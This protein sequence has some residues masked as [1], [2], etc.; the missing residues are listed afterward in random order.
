MGRLTSETNP[1]SGT[2]TYYYDTVPAGCY[3]FGDNQSGNLE[4]KGDANGNLDCFHYD[5][6]HR[7]GSIGTQNNPPNYAYCK[8][9]Q[10][11]AASNGVIGEPSGVTVNNVKG[12]LVEAETDNCGTWPPTPITDEWFSYTPRGEISD[13]WESTPHSGGY[14][15]STAS[16]WANGALN[17]LT[18]PGL[19]T[20]TYGVDGEGRP[21]TVSASS[22]QNP[23]TGTTYN[24]AGLVTGVTLGSADSD[25]FT[26]DPN[27]NRMTNYQFNV[28][29]QSLKATLTWNAIGTLGSLAISDPFNSADNQTCNYTHDD[30]VR[31]AS[32]N[33][34]SVWSQTFSYDAFGNINKNGSSSFQANYSA[35]TNRM[36]QIGSSTP[37]Y[38]ADGNVTNDFL[39]SYAWDAFGKPITIDGVGITYDALGRMVEQNRSGAYTQIVYAPQGQKLVLM[40][41]QSFQKAYL[42]LPGGLVA[43][44]NSSGCCVY[45][46][47]D[48]LGNYRLASLANRSEYFDGAY[49]PFGEP[50]TQSGG[51]VTLSFTGMNQDTVANLYDFPAREYGI[52]G[53][54][55][56][57]DPA[58]LAAV[59]P[60]NPQSWNRYAYVLNSPLIYADPTGM[61]H[62][63]PIPG[64]SSDNPSSCGGGIVSTPIQ[65][66]YP[67]VYSTGVPSLGINGLS[68]IG[69]TQVS[70][71]GIPMNDP[72]NIY[73]P[74][75]VLG[76]IATFFYGSGGSSGGGGG[77]DLGGFG[78]LQYQQYQ[79][80][81]LVKGLTPTVCGGGVFGYVGAARSYKGAEGFAG[82]LGEY[83]TKTGW[84]NNGL[85]EGGSDLVSGG[86]A[87]NKGGFEPLVFLPVAELG[88]VV[89]GSGKSAFGVG[90][91]FGTPRYGGGAYVNVTS[92]LSCE[93]Q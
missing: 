8:R 74:S 60:T 45:H 89:L 19:S 52:Q 50:Y 90:F 59:G 27:T 31:I 67:V 70:I 79:G 33:C 72:S 83:D 80:T 37:T 53:R 16:H 87:V 86:V 23:V 71:G 65:G 1:E 14:Y 55:P 66:N 30:L 58:G 13:V 63:A 81:R 92:M 69:A 15:H 84:S 44:Y 54:W 39:H 11:D 29:G 28:N 64:Q 22:G 43:A 91:Y 20:I 17:Q 57:P 76:G 7:L 25:V 93:G 48:W 68:V 49:G 36:T 46:H 9:F 78:A 34:G 77:G 75:S 18:A 85:F 38:D 88:G 24:S 47:P 41:G 32:A 51:S 3:S 62:C 10:Y 6:L 5:A 40:S 42:P 12:R 4:A 21:Q 61:N 56:S 2:T 82:Y 26:Y 73:G 35:S